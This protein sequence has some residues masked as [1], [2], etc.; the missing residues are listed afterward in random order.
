MYENVIMKPITLYANLKRERV[1]IGLGGHDLV[2]EPVFS[3]CE[4][5]GSSPG[6]ICECVYLHM[7]ITVI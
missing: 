3:R 1:I 4:G 2:A 6:L 7:L 5:L